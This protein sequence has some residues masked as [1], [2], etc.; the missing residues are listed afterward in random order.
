MADIEIITP[1]PCASI[2]D[3][4]RFGWRRY[5]V[6]PAGAMDR[7]ALIIANA[8][9]GNDPNAAAIECA[10]TISFRVLC[11][12][13]VIAITG[14][15][16]GLSLND[17]PQ[18]P[19]QSLS[20]KQNDIIK[21]TPAPDAL[22]AY[23]TFA[24]NG[25]ACK[26]I[27][28]SRSVHA[29]AHIGGVDGKALKAGAKLDLL[30]TSLGEISPMNFAPGQ[31]ARTPQT[32]IRVIAG[33]QADYFSQSTWRDFLKNPFTITNRRD[34][35]GTFL[36][37]PE[38]A[39]EKSANIISDGALPGAIQVPGSGQ[40]LVLMNDGPP[41]GGYPK[42][43]AIISADLPRFAQLPTAARLTF[44]QI[45]IDHAEHLARTRH[46]YIQSLIKTVS[47]PAGL[48]AANLIS[49]VTSGNDGAPDSWDKTPKKPVQK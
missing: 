8:L 26:P 33:P 3:L 19:Y 9:V 41:T 48:G 30:E 14:G 16:F 18:A 23:I 5:G 39:H 27:L 49:G 6:A 28:G 7:E 36:E 35:M 12:H 43:A 24:G 2:Q 38:L 40:P 29:R 21:I 31:L 11:E 15:A 1:G 46:K 32:P 42:I 17:T 25:I 47:A 34:R 44:E 10:M 4:G 22:Y 37:G 13:T 20:I 45:T